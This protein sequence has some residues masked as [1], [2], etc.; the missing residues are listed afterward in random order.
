MLD[1]TSVAAAAALTA[2]TA[3]YVWWWVVGWGTLFVGAKLQ[4][5]GD[6]CVDRCI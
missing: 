1:S 3:T 6:V 5:T 2:A 4:I